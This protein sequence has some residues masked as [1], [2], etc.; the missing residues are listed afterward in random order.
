[1]IEHGKTVWTSKIPSDVWKFCDLDDIMLSFANKLLLGEKPDQWSE[2]YLLP[3]QK[4]GDLSDTS[5]G[6]ALSAVAAKIANKLIL[7]R[8][9]PKIDK[10]L[11]NNQNGFRPG[12]FTIAHILS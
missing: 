3:I 5:K 1:M 9:R 6:I 2:N 7:N 11:R 4:D 12:R 8:I 10:Y